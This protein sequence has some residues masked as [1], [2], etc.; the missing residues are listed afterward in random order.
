MWIQERKK[1][2]V[3]Q[4]GEQTRNRETRRVWD[5]EHFLGWLLGALVT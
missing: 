2:V 4:T 3:R 1:P 5:R